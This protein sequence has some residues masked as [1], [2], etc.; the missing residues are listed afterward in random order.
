MV[1]AA[2]L[3]GL[4]RDFARK[5]KTYFRDNY[6]TATPQNSLRR[7]RR[8]QIAEWIAGLP[9]LRRVLDVG[10]GPALLYPE[11]YDRCQAYY[12]VD[13]VESNLEEVRARH[14]R[15]VTVRADLDT[16]EWTHEPPTLI[17]CAGCLEYSADPERN[18]ASLCRLLAPGGVIVASF[19]NARSPHRIWYEN[20]HRPLVRLL[21]FSG[22]QPTYPRR[23][24]RLPAVEA[25]LAREGMDL[26][27]VRRL[28]YC[29]VPPP[30]DSWLPGLA[31]RVRKLLAR[32][33]P[34]LGGLSFEF[35]VMARRRA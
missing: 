18:L 13:V 21:D 11:A 32:R 25:V 2:Q 7:E 22:R 16:L 5:R 29:F 23:L 30:L 15:A 8:E 33:L 4:E 24:S 10:C 31:L 12:A 34:G 1:D 35:L 9:D 6:E 14:D 27:A 28:G 26:V 19:A 3:S 17:V 20:V